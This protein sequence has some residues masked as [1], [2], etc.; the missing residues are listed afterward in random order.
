MTVTRVARAWFGLTAG[1]IVVGV[2][3]QLFVSYDKTD[4]YFS[5]PWERVFNVFVFFTIQSNLIA[6]AGC[7][8]L[9]TG[10]VPTSLL[11]RAVR[12]LGV[13]GIALT[14][15]VFQLVLRQL[16]DLTGGAAF[17]DVLLHTI[18]PLMCVSGWALFGP[19]RLVDRA[20]IGLTVVYLFLWGAFTM[21]RGDMVGFYPYPFTDPTDHGYLRVGVNLIIVGAV[22]VALGMLGMRLDRWLAR[23]S[24]GTTNEAMGM[25]AS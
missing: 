16:Q 9:A 24:A 22:F 25:P 5:G 12:L 8:V 15:I 6:A 18:A 11:F 2:V 1:I 3:V 17:A 7:A 14:F 4:G 19:R 21:I 20:A 13:L 10:E 23:R